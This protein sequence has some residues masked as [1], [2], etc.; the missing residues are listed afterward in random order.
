[1]S[2]SQPSGVIHSLQ[3]VRDKVK[4]RLMKVPEYRAFLAIEMPIAEVA[5]IPD[6]VAHLQTAKQKILERLTTT[7][8]YRALLTVEKAIKD[9]SEVLDVVGNDA[10]VDAAPAAAEKVAAK[11]ASQEARKEEAA[12]K[13]DVPAAA[14]PAAAAAE[15][16]SAPAIAIVAP[17][18]AAPAVIATAAA[19]AKETPETY[20]RDAADIAAAIEASGEHHKRPVANPNERLST[21]GHVEEWRLTALVRES[22]SANLDHEDAR[23]AG[24]GKATAE[25]KVA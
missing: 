15:Q 10:N 4:L 7:Q 6:L 5:D 12:R 16:Q 19:A 9:I 21:L 22:Y 24:E 25:A 20:A 2:Q 8:E 18:A 11:E 14:P 1:M 13:E 23:S 3:T 17:P